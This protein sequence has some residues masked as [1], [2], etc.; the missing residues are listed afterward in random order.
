MGDGCLLTSTI[1]GACA[2]AGGLLLTPELIRD[3]APP[4]RLPEVSKDCFFAVV[5]KA[6]GPVGGIA[7]THLS[8]G[9][10]VMKPEVKL[11]N[12]EFGLPPLKAFEWYGFYPQES[13]ASSSKKQ[14]DTGPGYLK[15]GDMPAPG[16]LEG[17]IFRI[18]YK[19]YQALMKY[20]TDWNSK[21]Q[22]NEKLTTYNLSTY[23]CTDWVDEAISKS[24]GSKDY[25]RFKKDGVTSTP[26]FYAQYVQV[27]YP[28]SVTEVPYEGN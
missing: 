12:H 21:E 28:Q 26:K 14:S 18:T 22:L 9:L 2:L 3:V 10:L 25:P 24:L 16:K 7:G 27:Y 11:S 20:I 19:Q 1:F 13:S 8:L 6:E 4:K 17:A 15:F 5:S 23:N